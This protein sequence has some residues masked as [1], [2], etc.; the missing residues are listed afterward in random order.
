VQFRLTLPLVSLLL[1]LSFIGVTG[2]DPGQLRHEEAVAPERLD[3]RATPLVGT[4]RWSASG[5]RIGDINLGEE[6]FVFREDGTYAV[7]STAEDGWSEC[8]EGTFTWS[9]AG[10]PT[11]GTIVFRASRVQNDGFARDVYLDDED[12][13]HFGEGGTYVRTGPVVSVHCP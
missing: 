3:T 1:S 12:R 13:L 7:V 4:W 8:Y 5:T 6:Q 11:R 10:E 9:S 2:C